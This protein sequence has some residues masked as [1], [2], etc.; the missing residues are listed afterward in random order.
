MDLKR[1][2]AK[3]NPQLNLD[4]ASDLSSERKPTLGGQKASVTVLKSFTD[5]KQNASKLFALR[6][7]LEHARSLSW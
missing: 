4:L 1:M 3:D 7:I 5:K 6:K 2:R